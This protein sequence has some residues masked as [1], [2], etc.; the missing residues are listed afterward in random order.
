[1]DAEQ[2]GS[3]PSWLCVVGPSVLG[4]TTPF[5]GWDYTA[6]NR[7]DAYSLEVLLD[8]GLQ[9]RELVATL[10]KRAFVQ[11][12]VVQLCSFLARKLCSLLSGYF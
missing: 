4:F 6:R 12:H 8:S 3:V 7:L 5:S 11:L 2:Q 9:L 10:A 1:M